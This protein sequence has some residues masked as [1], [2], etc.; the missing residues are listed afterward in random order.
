MEKKTV[1]Y[2]SVFER[3]YEKGEKGIGKEQ[4]KYPIEYGEEILEDK[5]K[6]TIHRKKLK[7]LKKQIKDHATPDVSKYLSKLDT[8]TKLVFDYKKKMDKHKRTK[9][10]MTSTTLHTQEKKNFAPKSILKKLSF[11]LKTKQFKM[12]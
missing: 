12:K 8:L 3:K 4:V 2:G 11:K 9:L 5:R 7:D 10:K 1:A 6:Y